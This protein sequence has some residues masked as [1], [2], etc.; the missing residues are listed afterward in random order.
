[1]TQDMSYEM[2]SMR[3]Y[4]RVKMPGQKAKRMVK[5][6]LLLTLKEFKKDHPDKDLALSTF[7]NLRCSSNP[8]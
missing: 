8:F 1:M 5:H 4:V 3:D 7:A 2:P 6:V